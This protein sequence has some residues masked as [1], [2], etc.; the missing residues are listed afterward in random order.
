M[1]L[2][3]NDIHRQMGANALRDEIDC[4]LD[5]DAARKQQ[6]KNGHAESV[7]EQLNGR[8]ASHGHSLPDLE[9]IAVNKQR[10]AAALELIGVLAERFPACFA[11]RLIAD[12]SSSASTSIFSLS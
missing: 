4:A 12:R 9:L 3:A 1:K 8:A 11:T 6:Q 2:D 7:F 5:P 10:L